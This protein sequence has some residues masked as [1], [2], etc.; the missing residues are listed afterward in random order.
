VS[1]VQAFIEKTRSLPLVRGDTVGRLNRIRAAVIEECVEKSFRNA[2]IAA[3]AKRARVSTASLYREFANRETLL[4]TVVRFAAPMLATEFSRDVEINE[5]QQRL[6]ALLIHH[7]QIYRNPHVNW[8]YRAHV[9]GEVL[10]GR[11]L[12]Q[13]G[14]ETSNGIE[15]FWSKEIACLQNIDS[16]SPK[17]VQH[18]LNFT[19]GA[20]QRRS[21]TSMLLFGPNDQAEPNLEVAAKSVLDWV[22]ALYTTGSEQ[23][24]LRPINRAN[25]PKPTAEKSP[26]ERQVARDLNAQLDRS[27]VAGRHTKILAAAVQECS[28]MGFKNAS[29]VGVTHRANVSTAT[30][31]EHF[32]DKD[33]M[34]IKSVGYMV[35]ILTQ[36]VTQI[37]AIADPRERIAAMLIKH[38]EAYLDPFMA[39]LFRLYVSFDGNDD[40]PT[41]KLG[42]ASRVMTEQFWREQ[43]KGLEDEGH[44][45]PSDHTVTINILLGGIERRTLTSFL[46]FG[47]SAG[48]EDRLFEAAIFAAEALFKRLGTDK[49]RSE[50]GQV[51]RVFEMN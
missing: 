50:F 26:I 2:S 34:F 46:L 36:A 30:L 24:Q 27:D 48:M 1:Q 4:E 47:H 31:Y 37:P 21:L 38:G 15:A 8:L 13:F 16:A 6:L 35:P 51:A 20:V 25:L 11:G 18:V 44:L 29:M 22:M 10:E 43:L 17:E 19:L 9:S 28:Q 42:H 39:W 7:G 33:D 5:P 49:Y 45:I 23:R 40:S 3:I 14:R 41:S 32:N 12:I